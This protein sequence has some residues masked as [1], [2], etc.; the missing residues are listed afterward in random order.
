MPRCAP[1]GREGALWLRRQACPGT[2]DGLH[3]RSRAPSGSLGMDVPEPGSNLLAR[4]GPRASRQSGLHHPASRSQESEPGPT[5]KISRP[6]TFHRGDSLYLQT[7][8]FEPF[9]TQRTQG[10]EGRAAGARPRVP[11]SSASPGTTSGA[12]LSERLTG[13]GRRGACQLPKGPIEAL[14]SP[15]CK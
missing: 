15:I 1:R 4:R 12:S 10:G 3:A 2:W 11:A 14:E 8:N 13:F 6:R 7:R 9:E 5:R